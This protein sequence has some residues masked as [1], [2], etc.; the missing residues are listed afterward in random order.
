MK[1]VTLPGQ[2][3]VWV[4]LNSPKHC[5]E[6]SSKQPNASGARAFCL[7]TDTYHTILPSILCCL[8][9]TRNALAD[10]A[11][12]SGGHR[13]RRVN[14]ESAHAH[15]HTHIA[16]TW[17]GFYHKTGGAKVREWSKRHGK[18]KAPTV[19]R[20]SAGDVRSRD[21]SMERPPRR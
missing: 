6:T 17:G 5:P 10:H 2:K 19:L 15:T 16:H 11:V 8:C 3:A 21:G 18:F 20:S 7:Q 13:A 9:N 4:S 1:G 12:P 14:S